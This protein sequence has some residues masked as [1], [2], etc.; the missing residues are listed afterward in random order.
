MVATAVSGGAGKQA[1]QSQ[2]VAL[3]RRLKR[4]LPPAAVARFRQLSKQLRACSLS[5]AAYST[6]MGEA[7]V[8]LP[9]FRDAVALLPGAEL[10]A[11][12]L[13]EIRGK[14]QD[15]FAGTLVTVGIRARSSL[16]P[17]HIT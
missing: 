2:K 14:E 9:L 6:A 5:A 1:H 10:R 13:G 11:A 15:P 8:P 3:M 7:G 17:P 4:E 12:V 16:L